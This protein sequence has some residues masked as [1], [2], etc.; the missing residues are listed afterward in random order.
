MPSL[1]AATVYSLS[2]CMTFS[3]AYAHLLCNLLSFSYLQ[4]FAQRRPFFHRLLDCEDELFAV[5]TAA[6]DRQSLVNGSSSF[7]E[8]L[9]GL[10]RNSIKRK[11][12]PKALLDQKA[13]YRTLFFLVSPTCSL[14][15]IHK[16]III[17]RQRHS[18]VCWLANRSLC[19]MCNQRW[20]L[21][22]TGIDRTQTYRWDCKSCTG[23]QKLSTALHR[24]AAACVLL[25]P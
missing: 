24:C 3:T 16:H 9:Y 12:S 19:H 10:R 25:L 11:S 17:G 4:V 6:L 2:V 22:T 5:I 20:R 8:S 1:K 18:V 23:G 21:C 15:S 14:I 7:A 13:Q